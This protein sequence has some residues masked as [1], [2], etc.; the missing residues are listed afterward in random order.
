MPPNPPSTSFGGDFG[1]VAPLLVTLSPPLYDGDNSLSS[2]KC[3]AIWRRSSKSWMLGITAFPGQH[4]MALE[5]F[6]PVAF[7]QNE[8]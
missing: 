2:R 7:S 6:I 1:Q 8:L 4:C 3:F 5:E